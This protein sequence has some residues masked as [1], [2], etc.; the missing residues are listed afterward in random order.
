MWCTHFGA[1]ARTVGPGLARGLRAE[2]RSR[3]PCWIALCYI[4]RIYSH[5]R[6]QAPNFT[7]NNV[8]FDPPTVPVL[9]QILSGHYSAQSLLPTGSVYTLPPNRVC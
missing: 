3:I 4:F 8:A 6:V 7:I 5:L 9:L 2:P 1:V